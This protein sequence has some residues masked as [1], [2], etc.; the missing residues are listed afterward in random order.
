MGPRTSRSSRTSSTNL[1][2]R[3][4][5]RVCFRHPVRGSARSNGG[6]FENV[7][8]GGYHGSSLQHARDAIGYDWKAYSFETSSYTVRSELRLHRTGS[9]KAISI[10]SG[11]WIFMAMTWT[12]RLP[13]FRNGSACKASQVPFI[14]ATRLPSWLH[15]PLSEATSFAARRISTSSVKR[16]EPLFPAAERLLVEVRRIDRVAPNS[17]V[18]HIVHGNNTA[19][20]SS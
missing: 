14:T 1:F 8:L 4:S 16:D 15:C 17:G 9:R 20:A 7:S 18:E 12:G 19:S 13:A 11:S 6:D 3:T 2:F 10:N 5:C